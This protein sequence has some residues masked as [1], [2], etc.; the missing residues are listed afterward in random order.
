MMVSIRV[1]MRANGY[2]Y[3]YS[4]VVSY[5]R[6]RC[7]LKKHISGQQV[8]SITHWASEF[9][10]GVFIERVSCAFAGRQLSKTQEFN[11]LKLKRKKNWQRFMQ[12]LFQFKYYYQRDSQHCTHI[13][14]T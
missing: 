12:I 2:N 1:Q 9:C 10:C 4:N 11:K 7:V 8:A 6:C 3:N 14:R 5:V 13:F